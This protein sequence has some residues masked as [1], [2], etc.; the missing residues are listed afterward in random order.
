[1]PSLTSSPDEA[2]FNLQLLSVVLKKIVAV[3]IL[4]IA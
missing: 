3:D 4:H 2:T 1:M